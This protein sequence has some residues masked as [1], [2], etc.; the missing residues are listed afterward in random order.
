MRMICQVLDF[1]ETG[2]EIL[3]FG[4][5][6]GALDVLIHGLE[7]QYDP[8]LVEVSLLKNNVPEN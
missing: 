2:D 5:D 7:A 8:G 4:M 3:T 6:D 1:T